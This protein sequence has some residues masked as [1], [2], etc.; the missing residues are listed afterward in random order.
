[1]IGP[2]VTGVGTGVSMRIG[3]VQTHDDPAV[4]DVD[5]V[6]SECHHLDRVPL[7]GGPLGVGLLDHPA[8]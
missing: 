7:A 1:M 6:V 4:H 8:G 3:V 5:G 2:D